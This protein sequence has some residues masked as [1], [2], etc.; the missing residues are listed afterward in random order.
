MAGQTSKDWDK[1]DE[2]E[3]REFWKAQKKAEKQ[4]VYDR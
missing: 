4:A 3:R 1:A 2:Q